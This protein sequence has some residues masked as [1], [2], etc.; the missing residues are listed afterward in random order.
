M[1]RVSQPPPDHVTLPI[2]FVDETD[3][4][5]DQANIFVLQPQ[6]DGVYLTVGQIQPPLLLGT[7]EEVRKQALELSYVPV[8]VVAKL[9]MTEKRARELR[10]VLLASAEALAK[11]G[12]I[13]ARPVAKI[14][15]GKGPIDS[16]QDCVDLSALFLKH[17]K[18]FLGA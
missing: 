4:T 17:A 8:K 14:R 3:R 5:F 13:P 18:L 1:G 6:P 9:V 11:S 16:A 12:V 10:D 7:Q 2:V 15:E